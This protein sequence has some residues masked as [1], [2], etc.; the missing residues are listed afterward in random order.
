MKINCKSCG[1]QLIVG[2]T[3]KIV[4]CSKCGKIQSVMQES[5][6]STPPKVDGADSI[7]HID[8]PI[9]AAAIEKVGK[10]IEENLEVIK[11]KSVINYFEIEL[12]TA[13]Y[14]QQTFSLPIGKFTFGRNSNSQNSFGQHFQIGVEDEYLSEAHFCVEVREFGNHHYAFLEDCNSAN[15]TIIELDNT[16]RSLDEGTEVPLRDLELIKAGNQ[17]LQVKQIN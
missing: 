15:G 2:A 13:G 7:L 6:S 16:E 10:P 5:A 1:I 3:T 12:I 9:K 11:P 17:I 4:K 14:P 8:T